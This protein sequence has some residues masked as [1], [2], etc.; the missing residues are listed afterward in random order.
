MRPIHHGPTKRRTIPDE[1]N[2]DSTLRVSLPV[3]EV[4]K[5]KKKKKKKEK[6]E[7]ER[8][9]NLRRQQQQ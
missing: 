9:E 6:G 5:K 7:E 2:E 3:S 8:E 1:R 4:K